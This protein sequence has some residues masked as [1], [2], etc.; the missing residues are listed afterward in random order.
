MA[1]FFAV[2][3]AGL[4]APPA[5]TFSKDVAPILFKRCVRCHRPGEIASTISLLAYDSARPWAKAI[6]EK[7]V[8]RE[9][10]PW[11]ADPNASVK[12]RNEVRLSRKE[13]DTLSAWADSG[14][15]KGNSADL[16]AVPNFPQ[17]WLHPQGL[18][19]DL[20]IS[21]PSEFAVPAQG[22]IPYVRF[23]AAVPFSGDKWVA[24]LQVR[25]GNPAVVHHMAITEVTLQEGMRPADL[26]A[27][28]LLARQMGMANSLP[29]SQPAVTDPGNPGAL[30]M[31][32]VYTPGTTLEMYGEDSGKLIK[33]GKNSYV[34][35]NIHYQPIGKPEKDRS[36]LGLWFRSGPPKRQL[37]RVP[38]ATQTIIVN[39]RELLSDSPGRKAEGTQ[40]VIPPIPPY[41]GNYEVTGIA[42]Y[43]EPI[44][45]SQFQPHAHVHCKDFRY[46]VVY[47][48]GREQTVL[49]V[50][51]YS[52]QWQL[53]Y[54]LE[55]PLRL[56]AGSK[57]IVTAHYDNSQNNKNNPAP[58]RPVYF[59]DSENQSTDEM[60]TP[61]IQYSSDG[62]GLGAA[63]IVE[64]DGCLE[65]NGRVWNLTSATELIES[66]SQAS[67][68][69]AL[70]AAETRPLGN[71]KYQLLGVNVFSP[72]GHSG[73]K[74]AVRGTLV[75]DTG[76]INVTS[77]QMAG[78][79]CGK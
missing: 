14:A 25:P 34:N 39:G 15:A 66:A 52:F 65:Q 21:M 1:S 76:R 64:A 78:S 43:T 68:S 74:V 61:F 31:L 79:G 3:F 40:A 48:D 32:G 22:Q 17:G 26:E 45:I 6:K 42:A 36:E 62:Q 59:R 18:P 75:K 20:V 77:L 37:L 44:T 46:I 16:P 58:D 5:P 30:D 8:T 12:F 51:K 72:S 56:P 35:F 57:L 53:A 41:A 9:M 11:P 24:A 73:Q 60:F 50:P 13:I 4:A 10:P 47:A 28:A 49:S 70:R 38:G 71:Q 55:T 27:M 19:P 67:S 33:G 7:V 2:E 29:G 69:A 54:D 23:L 63:G